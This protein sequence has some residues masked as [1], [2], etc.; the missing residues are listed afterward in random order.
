MNNLKLKKSL[1]LES[2]FKQLG[3][4]SGDTVLV[5]ADLSSVGRISR[6][7][8]LDELLQAVGPT[9]TVVSLS[10]TKSEYIWNNSRLAPFTAKTPSYAGALPNAMIV[11]SDA[12]RSS[13][14]QCSFVAIGKYARFITEGHGPNSEAYAPVRKIIE[15]NGKL[16]LIGCVSTSPGFTTT[17]LAEKDLS[18]HR[19]FVLPT[20]FGVT[21][22]L[23]E[24]NK[25]KLF[26]RTD[27]GLCSNS[28]WKFYSHYIRNELL[29]TG[30]IGSAYSVLANAKQ[31]YDLEKEILGKNSKFNICDD[32]M[33]VTCNVLRWDRVHKA[34]GFLGRKFYR[35]IFN[36]EKN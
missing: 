36:F 20:L 10:F 22:Y 17:H 11:H 23:D 34:P 15:I 13:H 4:L 14:P 21:P 8:F 1:N 33:C 28:Y 25:R 26:F 6:S 18:L 35:K 24:K 27:P 7:V 32:P 16:V 9:G 29:N 2:D 12:L 31:C 3:I 19:K 5:R 30:F